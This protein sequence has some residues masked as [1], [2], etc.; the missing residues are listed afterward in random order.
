I[1]IPPAI[2]FYYSTLF[3]SR[4]K[5]LQQN[6]PNLPQNYFPENDDKNKPKST[7]ASAA[8]LFFSNWLNYAVYQGTPYLGERLSQHL[9]EENYDFNQKEQK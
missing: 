6:Q 7:W 5:T 4:F 1:V 9:N 2:F 3:D 8:S